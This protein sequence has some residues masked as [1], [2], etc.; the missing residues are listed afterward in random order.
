MLYVIIISIVLFILYYTFKKDKDNLEINQFETDLGP[1]RGTVSERA[2]VSKLSQYGIPSQ[3]IFHDLYLK[4]YYGKYSQIDLVVP[5]KVGI[6]VFEVKDY[7]GWIFG[8]GYKPQWAQILNYGRD[9]YYFYNPILQNAK[10]IDDLKKQLKQFENIPFYSII[11]FYGNC[12]LKEINFVPNNTFVV[13]S[14]RVLEVVEKILSESILA[15]YSNKRE[16]VNLLEQAVKNG[17]NNE[18]I[19]QHSKN[20]NDMLGKERVYN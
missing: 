13:K 9:K 3:T 20:I 18:V 16:I 2:L 7:S 8:T 14:G 1:K 15:N 11:V 6:L 12:S 5:T 17:E 19:L 4:K 10:H